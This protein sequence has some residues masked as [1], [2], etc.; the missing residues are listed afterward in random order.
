[1]QPIRV[2]IAD[3]HHLVRSGIA[4]LLGRIAGLQVISQASD[5]RMALAQIKSH[6]P[7]V[8][9]I[10]LAMP[11][12]NGLD[13]TERLARDAPRVRVLILSMHANEEY[14]LRALQA[15]AAGYLVKD[16]QTEE[17]ELAVRAVARGQTFL[18]PAVSKRIVLDYVQSA[19][20]SSGP[21]D[22]LT[23][24]Q[25]E[26]LQLVAEGRTTKEIARLL[27]LRPKTVENH[28]ARLMER[29]DIHDVAGLVRLAIE[30][31]LVHTSPRLGPAK[32]RSTRPHRSTRPVV[33]DF[34]LGG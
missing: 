1:M 34:S 29:L 27:G 2:V 22:L 10:D 15:G 20:R 25:R 6:K 7:D 33:Q 17:L 28:R 4:L 21:L 12:L 30:A 19:R 32:K 18:S 16:G 8:A 13:L 11:V 9:L 24:R 14:V 5:G 3:D 23:L 31:G 26:I